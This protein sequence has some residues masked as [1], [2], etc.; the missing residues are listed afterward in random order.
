MKALWK[1]Y[2][3]SRYGETKT[4]GYIIHGDDHVPF[5]SKNYKDTRLNGQGTTV[6]F[7]LIELIKEE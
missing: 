4:L 7:D 6:S 3:Y 1:V 5:I 2:L